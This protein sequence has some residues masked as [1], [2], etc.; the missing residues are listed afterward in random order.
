MVGWIM[1]DLMTKGTLCQE[2]SALR[3]L[4]TVDD[5]GLRNETTWSGFLWYLGEPSG[6]TYVH[7]TSPGHQP[8]PCNNTRPIVELVN[9]SLKHNCDLLPALKPTRS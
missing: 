4:F 8:S 6:V 1:T 5:F 9:Q 2:K 7:D 3:N